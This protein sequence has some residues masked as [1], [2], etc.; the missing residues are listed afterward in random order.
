MTT[1]YRQYLREQGYSSLY[2]SADEP[3]TYF[4]LSDE[5]VERF[6]HRPEGYAGWTLETPDGK[7]LEFIRSEPGL[8]SDAVR[9]LSL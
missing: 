9:I 5:G 8:P 1:D 7:D 4:A 2:R 3:S 6:E